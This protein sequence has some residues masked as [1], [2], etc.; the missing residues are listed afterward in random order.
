MVLVSSEVSSGARN[1]ST[2]A[3]VCKEKIENLVSQ[4]RSKS[5]ISNS[6][7][8]RLSSQKPET[9]KNLMGLDVK[10]SFQKTILIFISPQIDDET[11]FFTQMVLFLD[12]SSHLYNWV[13]PSVRQSIGWS[14]GDA[15][16]K[17]AQNHV[18]LG[19]TTHFFK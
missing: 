6:T 8:F 14:V 16:V 9:S 4:Q 19:S 18:F 15:F 10:M 11:Y 1:G 2:S 13:S 3:N 17:N 5:R 7:F 12:A